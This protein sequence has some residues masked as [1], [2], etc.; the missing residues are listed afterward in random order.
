MAQWTDGT[1]LPPH[2]RPALGSGHKRAGKRLIERAAAKALRAQRVGSG[3]ARVTEG[4]LPEPVASKDGRVGAAIIQAH[5][6]PIEETVG[7][8]NAPGDS[9]TRRR[10]R[11]DSVAS[12]ACNSARTSVSARFSSICAAQS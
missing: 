1:I 3:D 2:P 8:Q 11:G 10:K 12:R 5:G 6:Q 9:G 4:D 7:G